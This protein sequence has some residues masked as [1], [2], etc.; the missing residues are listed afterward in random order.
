MSVVGDDIKCNHV[1]EETAAELHLVLSPNKTSSAKLMILLNEAEVAL[2]YLEPVKCTLLSEQTSTLIKN[3]QYH[4]TELT[5]SVLGVKSSGYWKIRYINEA[6][7]KNDRVCKFI[8][9]ARAIDLKCHSLS[10]KEIHIYCYSTRIYPSAACHLY[11]TESKEVTT[12]NMPLS[13]PT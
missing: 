10:S 7:V 5:V 1:E 11:Y 8:M 2:C 9:F 3:T 13:Q 4:Y 6:D 12:L